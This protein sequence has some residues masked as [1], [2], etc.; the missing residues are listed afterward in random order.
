MKEH[1]KYTYSVN[2]SD[3]DEVFIGRVAEFRSLT[4][5][6]DSPDRALAEIQSVVEEVIAELAE[7]GEPIPAPRTSRRFSGRFNVRM[8]TELHRRLVEDAESEGV[9]LN[10]LVV[11]RLAGR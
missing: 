5:H 8:P 1:L 7:E 3:E 2:W 11:T 6:G 10:Q 4:A 9:S